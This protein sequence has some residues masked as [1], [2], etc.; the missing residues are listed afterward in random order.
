MP[1]DREHGCWTRIV[2]INTVLRD[3]RSDNTQ[4]LFWFQ[5]T[6]WCTDKQNWRYILRYLEVTEVVQGNRCLL[7]LLQN[8]G[9][10]TLDFHL[11]NLH[12]IIVPTA[13]QRFSICLASRRIPIRI[14]LVASAFGCKIREFSISYENRLARNSMT[15]LLSD[16]NVVDRMHQSFFDEEPTIEEESVVLWKAAWTSEFLPVAN[17]FL[18]RLNHC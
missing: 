16:Q 14:W 17:E 15:F 9:R 13:A 11:H 12:S 6:D 2:Q 8:S 1:G 18:A 10:V 7:L 5:S 3:N 4:Q